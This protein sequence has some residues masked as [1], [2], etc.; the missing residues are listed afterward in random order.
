MPA[1]AVNGSQRQ[2]K[3]W[4]IEKAAKLIRSSTGRITANALLKTDGT[5]MGNLEVV[6]ICGVCD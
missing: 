4:L 3:H 6:R 1:V 5:T 2:E